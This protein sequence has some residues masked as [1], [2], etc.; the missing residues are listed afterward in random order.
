[1]KTLLLVDDETSILKMLSDYLR[2]SYNII[3][4]ING[5][6]ALK[7]V[8][9][10]SPDLVV[11]D[12][13]LPDINGPEIVAK[14]RSN[15]ETKDTPIIMLTAKGDERDKVYGFGA[16]ADDYLVK[17]FSL[18]ELGARIKS[19]LRRVDSSSD[20]I[21]SYGKIK[22]NTTSRDFVV[23]DIVVD[24]T[25]KEYK[26]MKLFMK[27]PNKTFMREELI[28]KVWG[29]KVIVSDRAVDVCI[30]RLRKILKNNGCDNLK[31]VRG[32]GYR[33]IAE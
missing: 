7:F 33:F 26:L 22:L 17:P 4:A 20:D 29:N 12:W 3:N 8:E 9:E 25:S 2:G 28:S 14:I 27:K 13:M 10:K 19:L 6:T 31:T 16:G 21:L 23:G 24:L 1:M 5:N 18:A 30:S 11:L 15:Q 32:I